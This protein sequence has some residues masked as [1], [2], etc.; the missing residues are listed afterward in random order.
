MLALA[1]IVNV[2]VAKPPFQFLQDKKLS[3]RLERRATAR[4]STYCDFYSFPA[5]FNA[6]GDKVA[7]EL[8][9]IGYEEHL[10]LYEPG[11]RRVFTPPRPSRGKFVVD[12]VNGKRITNRSRNWRFAY[13]D[14]PGWVTV[15]LKCYPLN[16]SIWNRF[17]FWKGKWK[18]YSCRTKD[19][20]SIPL[21]VAIEPYRWHTHHVW[22]TKNSW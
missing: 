2:N 21:R 10:P 13:D 17:A 14:S 22:K 7:M 11:Y 19:C 9:S 20:K 5:D 4:D 18:I 16:V 8:K 3:F 15:E 12:L 1:F 6:L